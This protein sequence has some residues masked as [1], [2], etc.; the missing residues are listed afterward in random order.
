MIRIGHGYDIHRFEDT[1][2]DK[3]V[4]LGG[5][6]I[7]HGHGMIA[8]SDGD[9]LIH[10]LCDALL[11]ALAL[12]DIGKHF[13]NTS[14]AY[15][16]IDSREL[17]RN[18]MQKVTAQHYTVGNID[19][20]IIAEV[21]K[22]LPHVNLMKEYLANDVATSVNNINIKATTAEGLGAIGEQKGIAVHAVCLL[23]KLGS[24]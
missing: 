6:P 2:T 5:V 16:N 3:G 17:L 1:L 21:P 4:I 23:Y 18:V 8:H 11:G 20:T 15:E 13:P 12:G 7:P 24:I 14:P 22:I 10:A 9:V 19:I